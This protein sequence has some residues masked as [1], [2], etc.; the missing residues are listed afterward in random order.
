MW[1][2]KD[3]IAA[4]PP[5]GFRDYPNAEISKETIIHIMV[6]D[7]QRIRLYGEKGYQVP[8]EIPPDVWEAFEKLTAAGYTKQLV[9][10][11]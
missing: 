4:S 11:W 7:L 9:S 2:E 3:V 5:L 6:G 1:P 8:Q 10:E